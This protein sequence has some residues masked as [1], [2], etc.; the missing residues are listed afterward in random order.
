MAITKAKK[1]EILA[2]LTDIAKN[3]PAITFVNFHKLTVADAT[4]IRREFRGKGIGYFV[5]KKTLIRKALAEAQIKGD[6]PELSGEVGVAYSTDLTAP[7]REVYV[8]QKKLDNAFSILGGVFDGKFVNKAEMTEIA[9]IP[10]LQTLYGMFANVINSPI[11]R[12]A[13]ALN[14]I[15][16]SKEQVNS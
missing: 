14:E 11:Q 9:A 12:F 1:E 3:N 6:L 2:K 7:A 10:S 4:S 15:A 16:K 8:F 13:V 5:A